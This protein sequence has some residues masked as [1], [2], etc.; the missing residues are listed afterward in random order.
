MLKSH[1]P[2]KLAMSVALIQVIY[3]SLILWNGMQLVKADQDRLLRESASLESTLLVQTLAPGILT[4][5]RSELLAVLELLRKQDHVKYAAVFDAHRELLASLGN[6]PPTTQDLT[7]FRYRSSTISGTYTIEHPVRY[8]RRTL[9]LLQIG[10]DNT[11]TE[12]L[13]Q[14]FLVESSVIA[15]LGLL[16]SIIAITAINAPINRGLH[17]VQHGINALKKGQWDH[18]IRLSKFNPASPLTQL[19]NSLAT[20]QEANWEEMRRQYGQLVRESQRLNAMLHGIKAVVWNIDPKQGRFLYVSGDAESLLGFPTDEWLREDFFEQH[21]HPSDLD[22]VKGFLT[23]PGM[24]SGSFTLDFRVYNSTKQRLWLRMISSAEINEQG[25]I[26]AGL[27]IDV[28]EE[29]CNEEQLAYLANHDPLT[30]LINRRCFQERLEEQ[31]TYNER[32]NSSVALLHI[33]LDQFKYINDYH[34]HHTGDEFLRQV[35]HH[36]KRSLRKSDIVGR[37]GGD[38][39]GIILPN[40]DAANARTAS[41]HLLK[42]LNS[43]EFI[44][45]GHHFP[46]QASIGIALFPTHGNKASELLARA[47]SAMY[48]AKDQGRNTCCTFEETVDVARM[49]DKVHWEERIR[50]ALKN[51]R[52][53]LHFQPIVDIH[54]GTITHYEG[55]LRMLGEND[56]IIFPGAFIGVAERFGMIRDIDRWV[57]INAIRAQGASVKAGKPVS[58]AVNLSGRHFG[59][60]QILGVIQDATRKFSAIP[61]RIV[62]E[63]TETAAVENFTE[64]RSFIQSL[65]KM[66]YRFAL[67]DFGTGFS[68]FDYLKKIPVDYIK[69]DGSFVRNLSRDPVDQVLVRTIADMARSLEVKAIAEFVENRETVEMLKGLGVPLAQGFFFARPQPRFHDYERLV[70]AQEA[71]VRQPAVA[72]V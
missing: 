40:T 61:D 31:I 8:K 66:G 6:P 14:T 30:G 41:K 59:N 51:D 29:K 9:G 67:D 52:F 35:A 7:E 19:I 33:D 62:F 27:L 53:R 37:L 23:H 60:T 44:H 39:F 70:I 47:D 71:E 69:I 65:R 21:I 49:Q 25:L 58:L 38:E 1:F 72:E 46:F 13:L 26:L 57:V 12:P 43:K 32:Y 5:N 68:S 56:E 16:V 4:K 24:T 20:Q 2:V 42:N 18:R 22:W 36:L 17:H 3:I 34:G 10:F 15:S 63:V 11:A 54:N 28:T 50:D 64:A 45:E 55:L 48:N